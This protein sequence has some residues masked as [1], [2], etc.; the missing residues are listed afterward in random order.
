[1][2]IETA[3]RLSDRLVCA[4]Q[5]HIDRG[6]SF[7]L[8][9]AN[10]NGGKSKKACRSVVALVVDDDPDARALEAAIVASVIGATVDVDEV[11][12]AANPDE[13]VQALLATPKPDFVILDWKI[14]DGGTHPMPGLVMAAIK[15]VGARHVLV[16]TAYPA[17]VCADLGVDV[18][19]KGCVEQLRA[20]IEKQ[21]KG[22]GC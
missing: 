10:G 14:L 13:A 5:A 3:R 22:M 17:G 2:P 9:K 12:T 18:I 4:A 6:G 1:M 20:W 11:I 19:S 15:Q 21:V 16:Y 8:T 7:P